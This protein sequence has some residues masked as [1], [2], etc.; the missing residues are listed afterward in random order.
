MRRTIKA[1]ITHGETHYIA[2]CLEIPVVTQGKTLDETMAN[3]EEAVA[4]FLEGEDL[5]ALD[6][7]PNPS[8]LV[9]FEVEPIANAG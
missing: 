1:Y 8:L 3:L 4:L 5:A 9:T 6:L 7:A 2:E